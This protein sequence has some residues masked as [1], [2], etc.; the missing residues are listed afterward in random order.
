[1]IP[2]DP[3]LPDKIITF[4][5]TGLVVK[6]HTG[7]KHIQESKTVFLDQKSLLGISSPLSPE[8]LR[9]TK[10]AQGKPCQVQGLQVLGDPFFG[11][12]PPRSEVTEN[13]PFVRP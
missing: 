11:L 8:K 6:A 4:C 2:G 5:G 1:M 10:T 3:L 9:A 12:G 13:W 7:G